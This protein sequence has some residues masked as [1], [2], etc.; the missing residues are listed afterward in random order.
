MTKQLLD[1]KHKKNL[2]Y[3]LIHK[4]Y[5]LI[6]GRKLGVPLWRLII[7]DLSKLTPSEWIPYADKFYGELKRHEDLYCNQQ[8]EISDAEFDELKKKVDARFKKAWLHHIHLNPHHWDHWVV[9][10]TQEA[11]K[12]P[13][14][15]V[16]EMVCDWWA[17]GKAK[18]KT[19]PQELHEW[20]THNANVMVLHD[21]TRKMVEALVDQLCL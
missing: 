14:H 12:M 9:P 18:G 7:H 16:R 13:D 15:F 6:A 21:T 20:Y 11:L 8:P 17:A 1:P 5:V 19:S 4:F 2:L 3:I 10:G